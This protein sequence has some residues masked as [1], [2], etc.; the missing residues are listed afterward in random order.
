[1]GIKDINKVI[2]G[3]AKQVPL[4]KFQGQTVGVD[5]M[6]W[7]YRFLRSPAYSFHEQPILK[8]FSN[9]INTFTKNGVIP[10]YVFDGEASTE[11]A[12]T[13]Q[14]RKDAH[15]TMKTRLEIYEEELLK[16]ES[17]IQP[18][19]DHAV[20]NKD[21]EINIED[22]EVLNLN[23]IEANEEDKE[24][25]DILDDLTNGNPFENM[26]NEDIRLKIK[27]MKMQSRV[28][29]YK[30]IKLC[31]KLFNFMNVKYIHAEGE[32]DEILASLEKNGIIEVVLS[33][34]MDMLTYGI[35]CLLNDMKS[36]KQGYT[37]KEYVLKDILTDF[38]WTHDQFVDFCILSGCDYVDRIPKLGV[39]TAK[40]Y[41]DT[42][43][44][45]ENVVA[46]LYRKKKC[47]MK[48]PDGYLEKVNKARNI[49]S[50]NKLHSLMIQK[51]N[52]DNQVFDENYDQEVVENEV[53]E[54]VENCDEVINNENGEVVENCDEE[55]DNENGEAVENCDEVVDE[56]NGEVADCEVVDENGEVVD[57][58]V[59]D[60]KNGEEI[61]DDYDMDTIN[62]MW[63]EMASSSVKKFT[64]DEKKA[65]F[66]KYDLPISDDNVKKTLKEDPKRKIQKGQ[67]QITNF[68]Q[69]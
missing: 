39:K 7:M 4:K 20:E 49:F 59:V 45:I 18:Q 61:E 23:E 9:Q 38:N 34:D 51:F 48:V 2:G 58:E 19:T 35:S 42:H 11:K 10:F 63:I 12:D 67:K 26:T 6:N 5:V 21:I 29:T 31:K 44:T 47:G 25:V 43:I 28:P 53:E 37:C 14:K 16:R 40:K 41:I 27:T 17:T 54:I 56:E 30:D 3:Y 32:A 66:N 1:M 36:G 13:I 57:C 22:K 60:G 68:F 55:I 46:A 24:I 52:T 8:G 65:F 15:N 64:L 33:A 50:M 69:K 62:N